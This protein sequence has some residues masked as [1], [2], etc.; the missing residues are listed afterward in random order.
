MPAYPD[1]YLLLADIYEQQGKKDEAVKVYKRALAEQGIS[2]KAKEY[3]KSRLEAV[4]ERP[5]QGH[6]N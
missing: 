3:I 2:P 5:K 6:A 1:A 4:K